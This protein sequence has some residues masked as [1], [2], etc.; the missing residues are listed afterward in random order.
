MYT[1]GIESILEAIV[2]EHYTII[3]NIELVVIIILT[4]IYIHVQ[5]HIHVHLCLQ[6]KR[7]MN[8]IMWYINMRLT[9][10]LTLTSSPVLEVQEE[11][12]WVESASLEEPLVG[13]HSVH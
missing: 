9:L 7:D 3:S 8:L 13:Q 1:I 4:A 12:H 5:R 2:S 6:I 11:G 10:T